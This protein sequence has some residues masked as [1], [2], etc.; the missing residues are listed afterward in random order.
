MRYSLFLIG[1]QRTRIAANVPLAL[2]MLLPVLVLLTSLTATGCADKDKE[3]WKKAETADSVEAFQQYLQERPK[4]KYVVQARERIDALDWQEAEEMGT[5]AAFQNYLR[6][7]SDGNYAVQARERIDALDWQEAEE[8]GTIAAFQNYLR[9]HSDGN[10][11]VQARERIDALDWQDAQATNTIVSYK[12]YVASYPT[13]RFVAQ[14]EAAIASLAADESLFLAAQGVGTRTAYEDFL[15]KYPGH[16]REPEARQALEDIMADIQ[17]QPVLD[18]IAQNKI[19]FKATGAGM[20]TVHLEVRRLVKHD[21]TVIIPAA[22]SLVTAG[23]A[24]NM[25]TMVQGKSVLKDDDWASVS[26]PAACANLH[27]QVPGVNDSFQ[28]GTVPRQDELEML[29]PLLANMSFD[30]RQAAVWIITDNADYD[31]LGR[32]VSGI[33]GFGPRAID[34]NEAA[35]AMKLVDDAGIDITQKA[36][37]WD[38]QRILEGLTG[39]TLRAWLQQR[40]G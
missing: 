6:E 30:V 23:S 24:Q 32:L 20:T 19:E 25:V 37:W 40:G 7:H 4:G 36:I 16:V 3:A 10:Y 39:E 35:Q 22:T 8:M 13:G 18:L 9:E 15:A 38:R 1:R 2:A 14:A 33:G 11:A 34:E 29:T 17:G 26:V 28:I 27:G 5:I 12:S 21:V 31:A